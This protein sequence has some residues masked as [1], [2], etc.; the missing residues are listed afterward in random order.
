MRATMH[1]SNTIHAP[2]NAHHTKDSYTHSTP[3]LRLWLQKRRNKATLTKAAQMK[4]WV[5]PRL[6]GH[7]QRLHAKRRLQ[8][9]TKAPI[10]AFV[11][12]NC[13]RFALPAEAQCQLHAYRL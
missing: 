8:L 1:R 9:E 4:L 10:G 6:L 2:P 11:F 5:E 13:K 3:G 12:R 7:D